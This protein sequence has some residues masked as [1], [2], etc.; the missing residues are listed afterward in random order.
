[1]I[2]YTYPQNSGDRAEFY[3]RALYIPIRGRNSEV[4]Q[5]GKQ[6]CREREAAGG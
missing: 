5:L 3:L 2:W 4:P 6:D 1:M